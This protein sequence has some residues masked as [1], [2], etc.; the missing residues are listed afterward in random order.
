MAQLAFGQ[1]PR[2]RQKRAGRGLHSEIAAILRKNP[3]QWARVLGRRSANSA[4]MISQG[5]LIAYRPAGAFE[6]RSSQRADGDGCDIW[7][8]YVGTPPEA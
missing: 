3:G 1:P 6:A 7:A 8:R 5:E 2:S 4:R